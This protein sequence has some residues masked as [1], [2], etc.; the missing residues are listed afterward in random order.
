MYENDDRIRGEVYNEEAF[1]QQMLFSGM[2][3]ERNITP[4]DWDFFL[5][6]SGN[7]FIYGE[8]K[9]KPS[10]LTTGQKMSLEHVCD[11]HNKAK[12]ISTGFCYQHEI[13]APSP[14]F[15]KDQIVLK[16]YWNGEWWYP[17]QKTT[18]ERFIEH[19]RT[20]CLKRGI[21]L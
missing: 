20:W 9:M 8:G 13:K 11:S 12:N 14:V 1:N 5:E 10:D 17:E 4:S 7:L 2:R 16:Y 19:V 3:Y 6:F 18:V 15:V 21:K